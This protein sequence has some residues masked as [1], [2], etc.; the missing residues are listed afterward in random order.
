MGENN[1][2]VK[3][4]RRLRAARKYFARI[5]MKTKKLVIVV[6][7]VILWFKIWYFGTK[8]KYCGSK[9][10]TWSKKF[11]SLIQKLVIVVKS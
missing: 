8:V 10:D 4:G 7:K 6:Q 3:D 1:V 5:I 2:Y 11:S 9:V